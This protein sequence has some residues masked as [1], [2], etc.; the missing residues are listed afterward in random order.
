MFTKIIIPNS[1]SVT[2]QLPE[3]FVGEE[4]MLIAMVEKKEK[5]TDTVG[6]KAGVI[7]KR[8]SVYPRVNLNNFSFDRDEANDFS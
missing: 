6:S 7:K 2:I 8:Y 4:V 1:S 5:K 3:S